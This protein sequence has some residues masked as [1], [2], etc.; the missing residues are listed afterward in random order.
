MNKDLG[1]NYISED[2]RKF[3]THLAVANNGMFAVRCGGLTNLTRPAME[4][5][6]WV[7][8]QPHR[9]WDYDHMFGILKIDYPLNPFYGGRYA[10][11]SFNINKCFKDIGIKNKDKDW[12]KNTLSDI[13]SCYGSV[14]FLGADYGVKWFKKIHSNCGNK[15]ILECTFVWDIL[16]LLMWGFDLIKCEDLDKFGKLNKIKNP[17][18]N[19]GIIFEV[20][21]RAD[22]LNVWG[23]LEEKGVLPQKTTKRPTKKKLITKKI[24]KK[25]QLKK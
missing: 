8:E 20:H 9:R 10:D 23:R 15:M 16:I 11:V 3:L 19:D 12:I 4:V 24:T 6:A 18:E 7:C 13:C 2:F 25:T 1:M 22:N 17:K 14:N 21:A 5:L